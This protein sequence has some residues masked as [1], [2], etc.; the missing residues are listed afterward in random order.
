MHCVHCW[1]KHEYPN[2][3]REGDGASMLGHKEPSSMQIPILM[4]CFIYT[5]GTSV[6]QTVAFG[7]VL[8][9]SKPMFCGRAKKERKI[10]RK[11]YSHREMSNV[12]CYE[13]FHIKFSVV[14]INALKF[15]NSQYQFDAM[16]NC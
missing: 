2:R 9:S 15:H 13:D 3:T 12:H 5:L 4:Q 7:F 11:L 8:L 1:C 16:K 6:I 10:Y 14:D